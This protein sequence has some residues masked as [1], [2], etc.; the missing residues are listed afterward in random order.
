M[1]N[2]WSYSNRLG[3][4]IKLLGT[5][6]PLTSLDESFSLEARWPRATGLLNRDRRQCRDRRIRYSKGSGA[7]LTQDWRTL[8]CIASERLRYF[9]PHRCTARH[10][11][12]RP[13]GDIEP[14][15]QLASALA[16]STFPSGPNKA[17]HSAKN[18]HWETKV[19]ARSPASAPPAGLRRLPGKQ[20]RYFEAAPMS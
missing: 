17:Y 15:F 9:H 6:C 14:V 11:L 4:K 13:P 5:R 18:H 8:P 3:C 7:A 10:S 1:A 16:S 19:S 2:A 12:H 20:H